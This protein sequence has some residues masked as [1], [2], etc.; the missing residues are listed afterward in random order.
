[1]RVSQIC[2]KTH[3]WLLRRWVVHHKEMCQPSHARAHDKISELVLAQAG[4]PGAGEREVAG[5]NRDRVKLGVWGA[6]WK[7]DQAQ[8]GDWTSLADVG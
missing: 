8:E 2:C 4:W 5:Q 6:V 3:L 7:A 1:M